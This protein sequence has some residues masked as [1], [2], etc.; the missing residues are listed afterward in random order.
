MQHLN[1]FMTLTPGNQLI[2]DLD[3]RRRCQTDLHG[4]VICHH[5]EIEIE[6]ERDD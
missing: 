3:D 6:R 5:T 2:N 1:L 4:R